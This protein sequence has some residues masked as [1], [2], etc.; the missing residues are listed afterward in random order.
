MISPLDLF[1]AIWRPFLASIIA[2]VVAF[3][4]VSWL[5]SSLAPILRLLTGG[6]IMGG[7]YVCILLLAMGQKSFYFA[8][9]GSLR[10]TSASPRLVTPAD[11]GG[12]VE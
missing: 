9:L 5:G 6:C 12:S 1:M 3:E 4:A 7:V 10:E 2:A 11:V 8:L